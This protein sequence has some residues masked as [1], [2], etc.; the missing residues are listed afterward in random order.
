MS[1]SESCCS[2]KDIWENLRGMMIPREHDT[3]N[4]YLP[5]LAGERDKLANML[6]LTGQFFSMEKSL[7]SNSFF[8]YYFALPQFPTKH[9]FINKKIVTSKRVMKKLRFPAFLGFLNIKS[10]KVSSGYVLRRSWN[11]VS[12]KSQI[13]Q[14]GNST[15]SC[16]SC[17]S[18]RYFMLQLLLLPLTLTAEKQKSHKLSRPQQQT[19]ATIWRLRGNCFLGL[20]MT[21]SKFDAV[22]E[23][24][25]CWLGCK[26]QQVQ[27]ARCWTLFPILLIH[28]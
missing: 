25:Y 9:F 20:V 7:F 11:S 2:R 28:S 16:A 24:I 23:T 19:V 5:N 6:V 15:S 14:T 4:A 13:R 3:W 10:W 27:W 26:C 12:V 8:Y 21:C 17:L 18:S 22:G 1:G